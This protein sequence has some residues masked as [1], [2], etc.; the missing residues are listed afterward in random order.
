MIKEFEITSSK[1]QVC[2]YTDYTY[3][4]KEN[5]YSSL[6]EAKYKTGFSYDIDNP[7]YIVKW[8][9]NQEAIE[10]K[11]EGLGADFKIDP[12]SKLLII[13]GKCFEIKISNKVIYNFDSSINELICYFLK[14]SGSIDHKLILPE[15]VCYEKEIPWN[16]FL[17]ISS[18]NK[19]NMKKISVEEFFN[20]EFD[21]E[22]NSL[23]GKYYYMNDSI[24]ER[25]YDATKRQW[26]AIVSAWKS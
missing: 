3:V 7:F 2:I 15:Y 4:Y 22:R 16:T 17:P 13:K 23:V 8:I 10:L 9:Y 14:K 11:I 26:G 20:I 24:Q 1:G 12:I 6:W 19:K 18:S 5:N 25:E 21:K